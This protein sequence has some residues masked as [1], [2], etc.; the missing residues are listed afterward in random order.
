MCTGQTTRPAAARCA[1]SIA[2][3]APPRQTPHSTI[4]AAAGAER[5][6]GCALRGESDAGR[7]DHGIRSNRADNPAH[8]GNRKRPTHAE[9]GVQGCGLAPQA[10]GHNGAQRAPRSKRRSQHVTIPA[11]K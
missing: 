11:A 3:L 7:R 2:K 10:R 9:R 4:G 5:C 8:G 1:S 6:F